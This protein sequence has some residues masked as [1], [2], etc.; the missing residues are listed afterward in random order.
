MVVFSPHKAAKDAPAWWRSATQEPFA[1]CQS[2]Q[3]TDWKQL[4]TCF[5]F[6]EVV[7]KYDDK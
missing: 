7:A 5:F 3:V 6:L 4:L 1:R 2:H